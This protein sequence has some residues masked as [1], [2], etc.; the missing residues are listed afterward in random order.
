MHVGAEDLLEAARHAVTSAYCP[1][2]RFRVGAA[3][4]ADER[5]YT[6]CNIENA[7]L[8]LAICAERVAIFNAVN[9]GARRISAMAITC[10]DVLPNAPQLMSMPCGAC[11]QVMAEFCEKGFVIH[12][13]KVG[14][15]DLAKIF[16]Y[17]FELSLD[18]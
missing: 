2:S 12:I 4:L 8:G 1:Y 16:P 17:P 9:T 15:F 6:G 7:S 13:D 5:I 10:P 3:V 14:N 18:R 11:R